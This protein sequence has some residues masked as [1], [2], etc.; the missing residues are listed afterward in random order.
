M[1]LH[2]IL[3][4]SSVTC[5]VF[6]AMILPAS[7]ADVEMESRLTKTQTENS[8]SG[9]KH[10]GNDQDS[11]SN[12]SGRDSSG[13]LA[14]KTVTI[15]SID[16]GFAWLRTSTST[17]RS[18][19]IEGDH[20]IISIGDITSP[21]LGA[22]ETGT[23]VMQNTE[24]DK[25][26]MRADVVRWHYLGD[27]SKCGYQVNFA[28]PGDPSRQV[29]YQRFTMC[30]DTTVMRENRFGILEC[31]AQDEEFLGVKTIGEFKD[32]F[33]VKVFCTRRIAHTDDRAGTEV[34]EIW[35]HPKSNHYLRKIRQ[36][37][38]TWGHPFS[39]KIS[40]TTPIFMFIGERNKPYQVVKAVRFINQS[41]PD[42]VD[43]FEKKPPADF[44]SY[45]VEG[46]VAKP[47]IIT[48]VPRCSTAK[49]DPS[50]L[51]DIELPGLI[52]MTD[53]KSQSSS[54]QTIHGYWATNFPLGKGSYAYGPF[55]N[56]DGFGRLITGGLPKIT[57]SRVRDTRYFKITFEGSI[58]LMT[59]KGV[60]LS[61]YQ[62]ATVKNITPSFYCFATPYK[63][64]TPW[65]EAYY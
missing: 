56:R 1:K 20:R 62:Y 47:G 41:E 31:D 43:E 26:D 29:F 35:F 53:Y 17:S 14:N 50:T 65:N 45:Q 55:W 34:H 52:M 10:S 42:P 19:R 58:S 40:R 48:F 33:G 61:G 64:S 39:E 23:V 27:S 18:Y 24:Y 13:R 6:L 15:K 22:Y 63:Y 11:V 46:A 59:K 2:E 5:Y 44:V 60:A 16:E 12:D 4:I 38:L 8:I 28:N 21:D 32:A 37:I 54:I 57:S 36:T 25:Y 49:D 7:C 3:R 51:D 30:R 9:N